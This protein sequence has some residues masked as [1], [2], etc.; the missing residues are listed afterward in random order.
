MASLKSS[1]YGV[2]VVPAHGTTGQV[3]IIYSVIRR[4]ALKDVVAIV[5]KFN[6]KAFYSIED[7][8]FASETIFPLVKSGSARRFYE[9]LGI[10]RKGK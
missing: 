6:P 3:N 2:T 10:R 1:G 5:K 8:K 4:S 9:L 7:V